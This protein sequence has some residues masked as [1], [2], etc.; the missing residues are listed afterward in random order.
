MGLRGEGMAKY[1]D[2]EE[3]P[4]FQD[5][6]RLAELNEKV[7]R[8][9]R[10]I[11]PDIADDMRR[12]SKSVVLN[13]REGATEFSPA[14][15]ARIYRISQREAGELCGAYALLEKLALDADDTRAAAPLA[16]NIIS[17]ITG[18]CHAALKRLQDPADPNTLAEGS[19][20]SPTQPASPT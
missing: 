17:Q 6:L 2:V 13:L 7:V 16:R 4:V 11:R 19:P 14:E 1:E 3:W 12:S 9:I 15:K 10:R 5:A 8:R 18:L 20:P